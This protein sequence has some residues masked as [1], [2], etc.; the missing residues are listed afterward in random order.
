[1]KKQGQHRVSSTYLKQFGF[2]DENNTWRISVYEHGNPKT[3]I[4]PIK[5]FTKESNIFD[6][7]F[8][9][10]K[11]HARRLFEENCQKVETFYPRVIKT[12]DKELKLIPE[13]KDQLAHFVPTLLC[14]NKY[15]RLLIPVLTDTTYR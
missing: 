11:D 7:S 13:A 6:I 1:M 2:R 8:L 14:R 5:S 4:K 3:Q 12:L 10:Y 15:F 9:D